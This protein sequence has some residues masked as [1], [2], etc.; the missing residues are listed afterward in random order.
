MTLTLGIALLAGLVSFLSPCVFPLVPAYIGYM[1]GRVTRTVAVQTAG[2]PTLAVPIATRVNTFLH[3]IA[4]V[5]GFTLVFVVFGLATTAF[6]FQIGGQNIAL[7]R[8]IIGRAGGLLIIFFGLQFAGFLT[9][10][11]RQFQARGWTRSPGFTLVA[12]ALMIGLALWAMVDI[13]F[14]IPVIAIILVWFV[15]GGAFQAP[16][17]FWARA[18]ARL[19]R[20]L[21]ADTRRQMDSATGKPAS[22]VSSGLMGIIFAAGWTPCIG[23]IYGS[24]LTLAANGSDIGGAAGLMVAYSLGL[25]IPFLLAALAMD[26]AQGLLRRLRR[27]LPTIERVAGIFMIVIGL[28]V[29]S[30]QLQMLSQN[31]AIQFADLSYRLEECAV[32]LSDGTISLGEF[33]GCVNDDPAPGA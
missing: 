29:A 11:F 28:L 2:G 32:Q 17:A 10:A 5:L 1:S 33:P 18:F 3:G 22:L 27:A 6:L 30:G 8:D 16:E 31:A 20:G 24:I 23:P 7:F 25:G 15:L 9:P 14:A 21:Y 4:F 12:L 13:L 26:G 19:E